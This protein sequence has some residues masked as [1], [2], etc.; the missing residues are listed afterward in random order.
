MK[1]EINYARAF[2]RGWWIIPLVAAA[3]VAV[4]A[5]VTRYQAEVYE[6]SAMLVVGPSTVTADTADV[7]RTI[8]TLERRTVLATFADFART[9]ETRRR[10]A[11]AI[12][13]PEEE[14]RHYHIRGSVVPNTNIVRIDVTGPDGKTAAAVA[15]AAAAETAR[16]AVMLYRVFTLQVLE[17]ADAPGTPS[18]PEPRRN[19][20]VGLVVGIFAGI[21]AVLVLERLR[22]SREPM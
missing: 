4:A 6:S 5:V 14:L 11:T 18:Y 19:Y 3:T 9:D 10:V 1:A 8:E 17:P 2:R 13:R 21:A 16:Q 15:D 12:Q 22:S 7:I 20:L